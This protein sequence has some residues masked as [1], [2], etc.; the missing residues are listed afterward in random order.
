MRVLRMCLI[1]FTDGG[2]DEVMR[3]MYI[4]TINRYISHY[5]HVKNAV[6]RC[7]M[8]E[9]LECFIHLLPPSRC[10]LS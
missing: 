5:A 7:E 3:N 1:D 4:Q 10:I 2:F 6:S 9:I 8:L